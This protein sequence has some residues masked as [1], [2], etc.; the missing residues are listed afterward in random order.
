MAGLN[1]DPVELGLIK[2]FAKPG[3]NVTG[4]HIRARPSYVKGLELLVWTEIE[5]KRIFEKA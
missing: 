4:V 2:S 1:A 3:G 5:I